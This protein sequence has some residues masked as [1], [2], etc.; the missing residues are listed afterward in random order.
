MKNLL[1]LL[2]GLMF[3]VSC[4]VNRNAVSS[5]SSANNDNAEIQNVDRDGS[6]Y[7]KA[8]IIDKKNETDGIAAEYAWL[9]KN[10]PNYK[11][12]AQSLSFHNKKP[13]DIL[14]IKDSSGKE[15]DIYFDIS[16]FFGKM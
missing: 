16:K 10:Y 12:S 7:D 2:I 11:F 14:H 1:I 8:I 5:V 9:E 6:S 13:Y 3:L 4:S 15:R